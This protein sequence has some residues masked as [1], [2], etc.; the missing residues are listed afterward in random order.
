MGLVNTSLDLLA[1][2]SVDCEG[3]FVMIIPARLPPDAEGLHANFVNVIK[4]VS[5][6]ALLLLSH[7]QVNTGTH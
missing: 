2:Y 3:D 6:V 5:D 7:S 1:I 4:T